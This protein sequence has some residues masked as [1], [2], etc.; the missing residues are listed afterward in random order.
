MALHPFKALLTDVTDHFDRA[1]RLAALAV[2]QYFGVVSGV[3]FV[4]H[5]RAFRVVV[6][7]DVKKGGPLA[8]SF[9]MGVKLVRICTFNNLFH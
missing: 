2:L 7:S 5:L 3:P 9:E 4:N 1:P 8:P 6:A